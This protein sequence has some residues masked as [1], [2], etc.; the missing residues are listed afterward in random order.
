MYWESKRRF[1]LLPHSGL[2]I[3]YK[4]FKTGRIDRGLM[5]IRGFKFHSKYK[6]LMRGLVNS[7]GFSL[8]VMFCPKF[9]DYHRVVVLVKDAF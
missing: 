8:I 7:Y 1:K 6:I 4:E 9:V 3:H 2:G 5:E